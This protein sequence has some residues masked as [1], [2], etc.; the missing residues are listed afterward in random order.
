MFLG[1]WVS[2]TITQIGYVPSAKTSNAA[3]PC[4]F[5]FFKCRSTTWHR[6]PH[7]LP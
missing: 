4:A 2:G 3:N 1:N 5:Q 7:F 6:M